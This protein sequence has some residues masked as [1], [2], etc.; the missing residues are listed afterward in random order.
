MAYTGRLPGGGGV[1]PYVGYIGL[2]R[3]EG[4]GFQAVYC[5]IGYTPGGVLRPKEVPFSG[6]RYIYERKGI[7]LV[8]V[9]KRLGKSV[10]WVCKEG[11]TDAFY[12]CEKKMVKTSG[13]V[14][15]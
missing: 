7:S 5:R 10:I 4:Y 1:L 3:S 15:Y 9:Y 11:L 14:T 13:C 2:C 8:K 6:L 12:G